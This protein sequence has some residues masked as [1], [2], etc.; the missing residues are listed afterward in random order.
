MSKE[1][2][3]YALKE[4]IEMAVSGLLDHWASEQFGKRKVEKGDMLW[5]CGPGRKEKLV[6]VGSIKVD[7]VVGQREAERRLPYKPWRANYHVLAQRGEETRAREVSLAPVVKKL[8]F[9]SEQHQRLN[10]AKPLGPQ[11]Q[12]MRQL[13]ADSAA[14]LRRLWGD[15]VDKASSEFDEIESKLQHIDKLDE[16]NTTLTRRE[17]AY[18]RKYLFGSDEA[19][20][21]VICGERF[22][23]ELLIAAHIKR[24]AKCTDA[25]RRDLANIVPMCLLG[26]DALFERGLVVVKKGKIEVRLEAGLNDRLKTLVDTLDGRLTTAWKSG[27]LRYFRWHARHT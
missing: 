1:W 2:L 10:P 6:T 5:I 3:I 15:V 27:R 20:T 25:E 4:N 23:I 8:R 16:E 18:L 12:T 11:L 14:L 9:K 19:G 17:Q 7:A 26:C 22:P 13:D 21:C 24:R